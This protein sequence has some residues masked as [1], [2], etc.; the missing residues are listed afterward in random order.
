MSLPIRKIVGAALLLSGFSICQLALAQAKTVEVTD[1]RP[2][3]KAVRII[4]GVYGV[5]ITYDDPIGIHDSQLHDVTEEVQRA[6]D[7]SHRVVVQKDMTISFTYK[8]PSSRL[9][10]SAGAAPVQRGT[11]AEAADAISSVLD[12]YGAS[13]GPVTFA[14]TEEDGIFHILPTNYLNKEGNIQRATPILD[15]KITIPA[16]QRSAAGLL[17]EICQA[18]SKTTG[19]RIGEGAAPTNLLAQTATTISGSDVTARSL[20]DQLLIE[21][22][23]PA[24]ENTSS[25]G[26]GVQVPM[27]D[28][29]VYKG[30]QLSWQLFYGPGWGY[31]LN[32][33]E[34]T[35][36]AK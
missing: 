20:L 11:A 5:A 7:P 15:T 34:V 1:G 2:I 16:K 36:D 28:R 17:Q 6:P 30:S 13:G 22:A 24:S 26:L 21:L 33:H 29:G 19:T 25:D 10:T 31:V 12:G 9:P 23:K 4:E 3:A 18:L 32:F 14:V 8:L 35:L 27:R